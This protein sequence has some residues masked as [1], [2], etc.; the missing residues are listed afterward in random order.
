MSGRPGQVQT[1]ARLAVA[2]ILGGKLSATRQSQFDLEVNAGNQ[3]RE[4]GEWA[5]ASEHYGNALELDENQDW[6]LVQYAHALKE[7]GKTLLALDAYRKAD[8]LSPKNPDTL[9]H[10]GYLLKDVGR[11][12]EAIEVFR[13]RQS[14]C[15][16]EAVDLELRELLALFESNSSSP[17]GGYGHDYSIVLPEFDVDFYRNGFSPGEEPSDPILHYL[18]EGWV[19]GRDPVAWFSTDSYLQANPDVSDARVNPFVHYLTQG[20]TEGRSPSPSRGA[21]APARHT[22][23]E[24][25]GFF[26]A[27]GP[28]AE[29]VD[30]TIAAR[31]QRKAKILAYY[32]PQFHAIPENDAWWGKGFTEWRNIVRGVPR[33]KGHYQPKVPSDLGFYDLTNE[34][35]LRRQV[36]MAAAAGVHGFCFYYYSFDGKR[37]LDYPIEKLLS[38]PDIDFPFCLMWANE[39][40]TKT[41]DGLDKHVLMAQHYKQEDEI[42]LIDDLARHFVDSRYIRI[43]DRPLFFIYR[44]GIIPEGRERIQRW[45][46]LFEARHNLRPLI[47]MA[48]GFGDTDP[49]LFGLDGAIEFPPHKLAADLPSK[50]RD[51]E[52]FD[53]NFSGHVVSYDDVVER[54]LEEL[55]PPFP[56]IKTA[57]PNWDNEARRPGR[58][59][60]MQ[61]S[62]PEKFEYWM[63][64]L[65]QQSALNPVYGERFV[66]VNAWNEWAEGAYLEPDVHYGGA[67]LNALSRAVV[68]VAAR[69]Q[70]DPRRVLIVGHDA[71]P[72]G[73]QM[74][75]R[76]LGRVMSEQFGYAVSFLICGDGPM[77]ADYRH[78]GEVSVVARGN[79]D[80]LRAQA[81]NL[82][83]HG[84]RDAVVNTTVSGW[85]VPILKEMGFSVTC[86][87]HELATLIGEYGLETE[88]EAIAKNADVVVFPAVEVR[89]SFIGVSGPIVG[90]V[91]IQPQGLYRT[92]LLDVREEPQGFRDGLGIPQNAK[93]VMNVGYAD[94]RKGFDL[95]VRTAMS[96]CALRPD[97]YF[98]W[99]GD[100]TADVKEW[101]MRDVKIGPFSDQIILT[102]FVDNVKDYY[103]AADVLFLTS[104]EDPFPS[105]VLEALAVGLPVLAFEGSGGCVALVSQ[106]GHVVDRN[107]QS[108]IDRMLVAMIDESDAQAAERRRE[109]VRN[110]FLFDT[111]AHDLLKLT[112][113]NLASVSVAVPSYNYARYMEDRLGSIFSQNYPILETL[114]LDDV[115]TDGSADAAIEAAT[116]AGRAIHLIV[117]K[118]NS[119]N[120]FRQWRAAVNL[121]RG[122]YLWIAEADDV[123]DPSFIDRLVAAMDASGAAFGFTDSWQIGPEDELLGDSYRPYINSIRAG[124]FDASFVMDGKEFL[125]KFLSIKNVVLNVSGVLWRRSALAEAMDAIGEELFEYKVAGDW[126]LYAQACLSGSV[127]FEV[128]ALNGHRRHATSVTHALAAQRHLDEIVMMQN[129]VSQHVE[130]DSFIED[131]QKRHLEGVK[132][133]LNVSEGL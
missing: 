53:P 71:Y 109:T 124:A 52:M 66:A 5:R 82:W 25:H 119:G 57:T 121:A 78:I 118:Q 103:A 54:S 6:L 106:H 105:V 4:R 108:A 130:V 69:R 95:F 74:L 28:M 20:H 43:C 133:Y 97:V 88:V 100:G 41:W 132:N 122:E 77:L 23:H 111:Y 58:G 59:M 51:L 56:L 47:F 22:V 29:A 32:L 37:I 68:G 79:T 42:S 86:L 44:P 64:R 26:T 123:A 31:K 18:S 83:S 102:G 33:F 30:S 27:P 19:Q 7:G 120:V 39:N 114:V 76:N 101:Q 96:V 21:E 75:V 24:E 91:V 84:V 129:L 8:F 131:K 115:S 87:I 45:R 73:A 126:R 10:W 65:V 50:N 90:E 1:M 89:D 92:E 36:E 94:A 55:A 99:V 81:A 40:W 17:L 49:N 113:R 70:G 3:A 14:V 13:G 80:E 117:N 107:D 35:A 93:I 62:T 61:G 12:S 127:V 104:R 16:D 72:H 125:A 110:D 2:K 112:D 116:R 48:Q 128:E 11:Y 63:R 38:S 15:Y 98:V 9:L 67:Y 60:L 46:D 34:D 85:V